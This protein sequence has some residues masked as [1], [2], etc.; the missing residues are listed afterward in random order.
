[1][2]VRVRVPATSANLGPG[3][4]ALGLALALHNEVIGEEAD[5]VAVAVEGEGAARLDAGAKNVVARGVALGFEVAGRP[6]RGARLR[7]VNRIPLSRGLGSSAA[8]WVGGLLAANALLG[9]PIDRDGLL[10]AA[11]RAEG[12]PDNVAAALLGGLTVSCADGPRV[13]AVSLPLP[14][15]IDWVVLVPETESSTHE[16]RAVLPDVVPR[17]DAVFNVQRVSLLLAALGAGRADLLDLAMQDR[18]HQPYRRRL[19]PWME[20]VAAAGRRAGA[21]GCV[22]SGAGPCLLAAVPARG[23]QV[24]AA[25]MAEA[26]L[27]AGIAGQALHLPVDPRGATWERL[28]QTGAAHN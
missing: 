25:S 28:P 10:A 27:A 20:E 22:L 13:T 3:F 15:G 6:F 4:D 21:L 2:R 16:A 17:A 26:L 12:H 5:E 11:T 24:V 19:F 9:E 1:M 7:C 18:L 23:G 8:A 14:A